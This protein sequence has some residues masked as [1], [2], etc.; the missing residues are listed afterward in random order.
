MHRHLAFTFAALVLV[1]GAAHADDDADLRERARVLES[2]IE[3]IENQRATVLEQSI[4]QYLIQNPGGAAGAQADGGLS[5]VTITAALTANSQIAAE[6]EPKNASIVTGD[7]DL[8]FHFNVTEN[9][10]LHIT[11]TA[12]TDPGGPGGFNVANY[13]FG[14][15]ITPIPNVPQ[16]DGR[17]TMSGW[18]DGIG[19]NG[20]T[21][22][23]SVDMGGLAIY[24]AYIHHRW[25]AG[26]RT[27]NWE[28]G[29]IDPRQRL[30]QNAFRD[31]ENTQFMNNVFDDSPSIMWLTMSKA[32]DSRPDGVVGLHFWTSF[33]AEGNHTVKLGWFNAPG[34]F[35]DGA[36]LFLEYHLLMQ[37]RNN[38]MN[39]R[40]TYQY[41][42]TFTDA[43]GD[44]GNAVALSWDW[45]ANERVGLFFT[46]ATN[47]NDINPVEHD[48][49]AGAEMQLLRNRP[50]DRFGVGAG[51]MI[52]NRAFIP[53]GDNS[54]LVVEV[55]YRYATENGKL[56]ITPYVMFI[57]DP[58][59]NTLTW[60]GNRRFIIFGFRIHVPF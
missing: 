18:T 57:S 4:E 38:P 6:L 14:G 49:T 16:A 30:M 37:V 54:E 23:V 58:G 34:E 15:A 40:I 21:P 1:S 60:V 5:G 9:L 59:G 50:H 7:V 12:N 28:L 36:Q 29:M 41:D 42:N 2:Q 10:D 22:V 11:A 39:I 13:G 47:F 45:L 19:T 3:A 17:Y 46:Y 24:E 25:G 35:W 52:A 53:S 27:V 32:V 31:N 48:F 8:G 51:L 43:S 33:G 55:Y 44:A 20:A 26:S 56:Q